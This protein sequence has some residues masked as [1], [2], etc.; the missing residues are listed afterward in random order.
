MGKFSC[1]RLSVHIRLESL[2]AAPCAF[3]WHRVYSFLSTN[4]SVPRHDIVALVSRRDSPHRHLAAYAV[5]C[6]SVDLAASTLMGDAVPPTISA[7][8][9]DQE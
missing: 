6:L 5:P 3:A 8:M 9:S 4:S 7:E 1:I 2:S